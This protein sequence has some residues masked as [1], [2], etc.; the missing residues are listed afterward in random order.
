MVQLYCLYTHHVHYLVNL[1]INSLFNAHFFIIYHYIMIIIITFI[2]LA[3]ER[4]WKLRM[5]FTCTD[6]IDQRT[7]K[8]LTNERK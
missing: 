1:V 5:Q 3:P 7:H 2:S 4:N 6:Y 8:S